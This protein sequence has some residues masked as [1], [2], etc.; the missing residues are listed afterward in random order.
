MGA[1]WGAGHNRGSVER[2]AYAGFLLVPR[3]GFRLA[4]L[5]E[6]GQKC[7]H[8]MWVSQRVAGFCR[9]HLQACHDVLGVDLLDWSI[10]T[11]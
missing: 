8:L 2:P 4:P 1:I 7:Q 6:L 10:Q 3:I 9:F 11:S 5:H